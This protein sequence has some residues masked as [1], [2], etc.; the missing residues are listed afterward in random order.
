M[1][2]R[3]TNVDDGLVN[4][5]MGYITHFLLEEKRDNS[6]IKAIGVQFDN[7]NVGKQ[8]GK[9]TA[10]GHIVL[11]ERIEEEVKVNKSNSIVR[12]QFPLKLSWACTAHKVQGMT[13]NQIVVNIDKS[14]SPGQAYVA[15]SRVKTLSGLFLLGFDK[16]SIKVNPAVIQEMT[17]LQSEPTLPNVQLALAHRPSAKR[18]P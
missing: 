13:A 12:H 14:F 5:V 2:I 10:N 4:G 15:F 6:C 17:R 18:H 9:K 3:N 7:K 16:T 8:T 1:L 11:I